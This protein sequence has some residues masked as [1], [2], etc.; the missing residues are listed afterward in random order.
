MSIPTHR[1]ARHISATAM[2]LVALAGCGS[3]NDGAA[4]VGTGS[5]IATIHDAFPEYRA[6]PDEKVQELATG[7]CRMIERIDPSH[8]DDVLVA[9]M[10]QDY[11]DGAKVDDF[12]VIIPASI[13]YTCP[14]WLW[15]ID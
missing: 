12:T 6:L 11:P 14:E 3:G 8:I 5:F 13:V 9:L 4:E 15:L 7:A 10:E 1:T 2:A